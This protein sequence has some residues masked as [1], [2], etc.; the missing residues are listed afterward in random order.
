MGQADAWLQNAQEEESIG[1]IHRSPPQ[2]VIRLRRERLKDAMREYRVEG[3][4]IPWV[5]V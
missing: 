2:Q 3:R 5:A 4:S 1:Q